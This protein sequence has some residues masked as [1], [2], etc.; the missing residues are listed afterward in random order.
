MDELPL[1][2][3]TGLFI[4]TNFIVRRITGEIDLEE[5]LK[6]KG[7]HYGSVLRAQAM[8]AMDNNGDVMNENLLQTAKKRKRAKREK[9]LQNMNAKR[10]RQEVANQ[11]VPN[12]CSK[13][14]NWYL[15]DKTLKYD[16][17]DLCYSCFSLK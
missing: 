1:D 10:R 11:P 5:K 9:R 15:D 13:C 2:P 14:L 8:S 16:S 6:Y 7:S 12:L 4:S 17:L 3:N